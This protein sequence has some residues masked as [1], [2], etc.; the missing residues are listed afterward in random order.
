MNDVM[1][2]LGM[3]SPSNPGKGTLVFSAPLHRQ[4]SQMVT[5]ELPLPIPLICLMTGPNLR[6]QVL[7]KAEKGEEVISDI[8][9]WIQGHHPGSSGIIYCLS[10]K[11]THVVCE[12]IVKESNGRIKCGVYHADLFEVCVYT[13]CLYGMSV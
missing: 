7:P 6:Y 8:V 5:T 3:P 4:Y 2:I 13:S 12:G 9:K 11:D 10:K 1:N